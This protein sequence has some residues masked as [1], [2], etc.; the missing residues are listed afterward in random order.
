MRQ[1]R[2]RARHVNSLESV[3]VRGRQLAVQDSDVCRPHQNHRL[4]CTN[5]WQ[6]SDWQAIPVS[7]SKV[8][9]V[10]L[11]P[12][13]GADLR[14]LS[15]QPDTSLH[16]ETTDTGLVYRAVWLFTLQLL[17][18]LI[19]L[20]YRWMARLSWPGWLVTYRDSLSVRRR[21]HIQVLTGPNVE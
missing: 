5:Q 15:P 20:T 19:A 17:L 11:E 7:L 8:S 12:Q 21:S 3:V 13:V 6:T 9:K 10:L 18:V 14:F 2:A 16:C 4:S 1:T